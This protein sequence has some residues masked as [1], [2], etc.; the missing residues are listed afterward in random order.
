MAVIYILSYLATCFIVA[1]IGK[2]RELGFLKAFLFSFFLSP[3]IGGLI[4]LNSDKIKPQ[5]YDP[6]F[7]E[8]KLQAEKLKRSGAKSFE[9]GNY[10]KA[11][12]ELEQALGLQ[13]NDASI[14]FALS[15]VF[16]KKE[17]KQ[18]AFKHL[19]KAVA[20]G[21]TNFEKIRTDENLQFL[22]N[23]SEF[24]EFMLNGYKMKEQQTIL[25]I[26]EEIERLLSLKERGVLT[27]EEFFQQ[28]AKILNRT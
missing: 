6:K 7:Y 16:S 1:T 9:S 13:P 2:N 10:D 26:S 23:Q 4:A 11:F 15:L 19:E 5:E 8:A 25:G 22:R 14:N 18:M 24:K 3:V 28:K 12:S 20:C 21:Y 27:E 17:N